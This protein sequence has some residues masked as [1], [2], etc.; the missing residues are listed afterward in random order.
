MISNPSPKQ[1]FMASAV[2]VQ[3]HQDMI[4]SQPFTT[5]VHYS[6]LQYAAELAFAKGATDIQQ[7]AANQF[8][9]LGAQELVFIIR[10]LGEQPTPVKPP[11]DL[12]NLEVR[13]GGN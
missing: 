10:N 12:V 7:A 9:L 6:L 5:A 8:R 13:R 3:A 4:K 2:A 11:Q 1:E